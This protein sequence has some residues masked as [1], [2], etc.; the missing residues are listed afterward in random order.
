MM[1]YLCLLGSNLELQGGCASPL[2]KFAP[3]HIAKVN[4]AT[5]H[6]GQ[7]FNPTPFNG[8]R[9]EQQPQLIVLRYRWP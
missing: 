9:V 4:Y 1:A 7:L 2:Y 5:K 6:L 8:M 3:V